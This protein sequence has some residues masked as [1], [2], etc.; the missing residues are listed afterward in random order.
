[1]ASSCRKPAPLIFSSDIAERWATFELDFSHYIN[2]AHRN[3]PVAVKA[4]LLLN[5]AGLDAM[6]RART[7]TYDP[8]VLGP[9]D[10]VQI[11]LETADGPVCLLR[12]FRE[13]C[14]LPSNRILERARFFTRKQLLEEPVE[15]FIADLRYLAQRCRFGAMTDQL[16]RDILVTGML[17]QRLRSELLRKPDLTL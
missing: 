13:I 17:D 2:I 15:C 6:R 16:T 10:Q 5:L 7:F 11:P 9:D 1:M 8:P 4:S 14:D 12:K 3:E